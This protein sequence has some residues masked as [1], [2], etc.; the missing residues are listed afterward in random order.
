MV[1]SSLTFS[2]LYCRFL[3][4]NPLFVPISLQFRQVSTI[5]QL[6]DIWST[7]HKGYGNVLLLAPRICDFFF[8]KKVTSLR[9]ALPVSIHQLIVNSLGMRNC[10]RII[11]RRKGVILSS[12]QPKKE[13]F[14]TFQLYLA[15]RLLDSGTL[16][17]HL[18]L[19]PHSD[20][21]V[22]SCKR[23]GFSSSS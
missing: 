2:K 8:I 12:M 5:F 18:Q 17:H 23:Y 6:I 22:V 14:K 10:Y 7:P 4:F 1:R 21:D 9:L 3:N 11:D 19:H 13:F 20:S 16:W 15:C